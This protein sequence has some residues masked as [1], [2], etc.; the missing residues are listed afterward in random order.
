MSDQPNLH[1]IERQPFPDFNEQHGYLERVTVS[2]E[3]EAIAAFADEYRIDK[4]DIEVRPI[5]MRWVEEPLDLEDETPDATAVE[6][7]CWLEC[8]ADHPDAVPFWKEGP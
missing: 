5:H 3:R 4:R 1:G 6:F 2:T 7:S 8:S